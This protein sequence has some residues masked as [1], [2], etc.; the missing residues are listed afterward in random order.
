M[1]KLLLII[2]AVFISVAVYADFPIT[3][4]GKAAATVIVPKNMTKAQELAVNEFISYI[5][6]ISGAVLPTS[7]IPT[8]KNDIYIGQTDQ[9]KA[10]LKGFDWNSLKTDGIYFRCNG[11]DRLVITGDEK[12]GEIYAVYSFLEEQIGVKYY[13]SDEEYIPTKKTVSIKKLDY[14]F[15]PKIFSR[16][17]Y[18]KEMYKNKP[19]YA[20]KI[21]QNGHGLWNLPDEYGGAVVLYGFAHTF[22]SLMNPNTYG[23]DHPDWFAFRDGKRILDPR[24]TQLCLTNQDMVKELTNNVLKTIEEN[25]KYKIFSV[26]QYDNSNYCMCDKCKALSEKHGHSGALLTV[27]N[28]VADAVKEKYPDKFIETFAYHYTQQPPISDIKPRDN[29]IIRLCSIEANFAK[30]FEH[31]SNEAFMKSLKGWADIS[32]QLYIWDYSV[33]FP[34]H[35]MPFPNTQVLQPNMQTLVNNK[36]VAVFS[37]G[38][39]ANRNGWLIRY[40]GYIIS[41]LTWDPDIDIDK[42]TKGFCDFYYGPAGKDMYKYIKTIEKQMDSVDFYVRE[43][44]QQ[45][46]YWTY[47]QWMEGF[48]I[49]NDAI[50]KVKGNKKYFDRV[51]DD[52]LGYTAGALSAKRETYLKLCDANVM[53]FDNSI[54][55]MTEYLKIKDEREMP[56]PAEHFVW[57]NHFDGLLTTAKTGTI[58]EEVKDLPANMWIDF[59]P[60]NMFFGYKYSNDQVLKIVDDPAAPNGK[61]IW[62][63]SAYKDWVMMINCV[64][65]MSSKHKYV[66]MY[67]TYKVDPDETVDE[68]AFD[69]G[70][71]CH[72][73]KYAVKSYIRSDETPDGKYKTKKL[74]TFDLDQTSNDGYFYAAGMGKEKVS[75]GLYIDRIFFVYHD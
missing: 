27:I 20:L 46:P 2:A 72:T 34:N 51:Y 52:Y 39:E 6:K 63:N 28:Q 5:E 42:E 65:L 17:S 53:P 10:L 62:L 49:L 73:T 59:K 48:K 74:G 66:D 75:K 15:V 64:Y 57:D 67:M 43:N 11:N 19:T 29:V 3:R 35:L 58:P 23:N 21:K 14:K 33:N 25:K 37:E 69:V 41:K 68:K 54:D 36:T 60:D 45:L 71:Y 1:K 47:D 40:K 31:P 24:L 16:E 9:T 55:L 7:E 4:G 44:I 8:G 56:S 30:P 70:L 61:A 13:L 32:K 38:D 26:T 50:S 22:E 18:Y 12:A